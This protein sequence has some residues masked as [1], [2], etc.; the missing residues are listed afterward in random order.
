MKI[1]QR[2]Q[3]T[4]IEHV[5]SGITR[6][7][8]AHDGVNALVGLLISHEEPA[9]KSVGLTISSVS[10]RGSLLFQALNEWAQN[11]QGAQGDQ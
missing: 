6:S 5:L 10:Q 3:K 1:A 9:V 11:Q 7:Q 8:I 2:L 4:A